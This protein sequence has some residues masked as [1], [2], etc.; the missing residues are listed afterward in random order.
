LTILLLELIFPKSRNSAASRIRGTVFLCCYFAANA[1]IF[2]V[3]YREMG[4]LGIKPLFTIDLSFL[5]ASAYSP[6]RFV[7]GIVTTLLILQPFEFF[8]YWFH[9]LQHTS[10]FLWAFH[11]EHH[12][13]EEMSALNCYHHISEDLFRFPF[14]TIPTSL[15]FHFQQGY[16]P[17]IIVTVLGLQSIY[18]HSSTTLNIGWLR[19]VYPDN[20]YHRI[21]HS[22]EPEHFNKNFGS[23]SAVWDFMFGTLYR[24]KPGEWPQTGVE[25]SPEAHN[26]STYFSRPFRK[27]AS[28]FRRETSIEETAAASTAQTEPATASIT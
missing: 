25:G 23:A 11:A 24:P 10:R 13:L 22:R 19:Y 15:L 7:G 21:H 2:P 27:V 5:S 28:E 8:Y 16:V 4:A 6:L 18:E 17:W 20:R 14:I 3:I 9:R 26:V 12:S 1:L